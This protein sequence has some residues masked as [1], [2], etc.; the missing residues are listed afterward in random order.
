MLPV[1]GMMMNA[2]MVA[3]FLYNKRS[4]AEISTSPRND[5]YPGT[6]P[7]LN[8]NIFHAVRSP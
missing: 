6:I 8:E 3:V 7:T 1:N 5:S 4:A 2:P